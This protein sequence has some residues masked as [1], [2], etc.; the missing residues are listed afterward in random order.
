[1]KFNT[2]HAQNIGMHLMY[3]QYTKHQ[4]GGYLTTT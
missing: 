3:I 2:S 1:M 4:E